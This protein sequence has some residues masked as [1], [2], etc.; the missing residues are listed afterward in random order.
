MRGC[1]YYCQVVILNYDS[2]DRLTEAHHSLHLHGHSFAVMTMGYGPQNS[3]TA[4]RPLSQFNQDIVCDTP[5]CAAARWN[6]SHDTC[7]IMAVTIL[8]SP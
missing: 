4:K 2:T 6:N 3:D 7:V 8:C 5:K 1:V